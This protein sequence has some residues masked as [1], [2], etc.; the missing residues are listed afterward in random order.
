MFTRFFIAL[1]SSIIYNILSMIMSK[2]KNRYLFGILIAL[3]YFLTDR[4]LNECVLF[5]L[6]FG[7]A[8]MGYKVSGWASFAVWIAFAV[9]AVCKRFRLDWKKTSPLF[10]IA[11]YFVCLLFSTWLNGLGFYR[12]LTIILNTMSVLLLIVMACDEEGN[13]KLFISSVSWLYLVFTALNA[14]S[15]LFRGAWSLLRAEYAE[16]FIGNFDT[17]GFAVELGMFYALL[18]AHFNAENKCSKYKLWAFI[19]FFF[20]DV[21][22]VFRTSGTTVIAAFLIALYLFIPFIKKW[23]EKAD[24]LVFVGFSVLMFATLM[25]FYKPILNSAP[26]SWLLNNVFHKSLSLS[27]RT[28]I[29]PWM[30]TDF[31]YK[32]PIFGFGINVNSFLIPTGRVDELGN[33]I[34]QYHTNNQILQTWYEGGIVALLVILALFIF[35]ANFLKKNKDRE[36]AGIIKWMLF[37]FMIAYNSDII[38][39]YGWTFIFEIMVMSVVMGHAK[40]KTV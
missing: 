11:G 39:T 19:V 34:I 14:F 3:V 10:F 32:K 37:V 30:L 13:A 28:D 31:I 27:G 8:D 23:A 26:I 25:W 6:V 15:I 20:L 17:S 18:D 38:P 36:F 40:G 24:L 4:A 33:Q 16:C 22:A 9:W 7:S 21:F 12:L 1:S 2:S 29:W 5:S 35:T